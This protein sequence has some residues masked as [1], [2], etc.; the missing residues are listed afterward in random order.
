MWS[1]GPMGSNLT[2]TQL[3][4]LFPPWAE[5]KNVSSKVKEHW[6]GFDSILTK[7]VMTLVFFGIKAI[8]NSI[9]ALANEISVESPFITSFSR[10]ALGGFWVTSS[11][12]AL[13][14][15]TISFFFYFFEQ[16]FLFSF[17]ILS[18]RLNKCLKKGLD[19]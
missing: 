12:A 10:Q 19:V 8:P 6:P 3:M 13:K 14:T 2:H 9:L 16:P 1:L 11:M 17:Y 4:N 15:V 5:G 7:K 18:R